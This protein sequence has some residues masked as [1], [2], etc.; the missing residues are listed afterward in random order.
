MTY[1]T[2]GKLNSAKNYPNRINTW[3]K[4]WK[5]NL[6]VFDYIVIFRF[7]LIFFVPLWILGGGTLVF[8]YYVEVQSKKISLEQSQKNLITLHKKII[9]EDFQ[10]LISNLSFLS[11][12]NELLQFLDGDISQKQKIALE[13]KTFSN[14]Q[15]YYDQIRFIDERGFEVVR[16]NNEDGNSAYIVPF[17]ELQYKGD[18]YYFR[19]T[20]QLT[21]GESFV[22][23]F[24]LNFENGKL[25]YPVKPVIRF[26]TSVFDRKNRK[27]GIV[28]FNYKGETLLHKLLRE[29]KNR[30]GSLIVLNKDSYWILA[31]DEED[32][33]GF[34]YN[35]QRRNNKF[36]LFNP[37]AWKRI[38]Q[39]LFGQFTDSTGMFTFITIFPDL[40]VK[41]SMAGIKN[42]EESMVFSSQ[43]SANYWK[44]ISHIPPDILLTETHPLLVFLLQLFGVLSA[45][46]FGISLLPTFVSI[47]RYQAEYSLKIINDELEKRV[48][49]RTYELR[50][51]NQKLREEIIERQIAETEVRKTMKKLADMKF[52]L[53]E[54]AIVG[55]TDPN[56]YLI[57]VN[58]QFCEITQS[59]RDELLGTRKSVINSE[60]LTKK[61]KLQILRTIS[62]GGVWKGVF[63]NRTK[64]GAFY[65]VD[66]TIVPLMDE[67]KKP[68]QYVVIHSDITYIK[69]AEA[70]LYQDMLENYSSGLAHEIGNPLG[71]IRMKVQTIQEELDEGELLWQELEDILSEIVRLSNIVK[72]FNALGRPS[73]PNFSSHDPRDL[74]LGLMPLIQSEVNQKRIRLKTEFGMQIGD[75]RVD[76]QQIQQVLLNLVVNAFQAMPN[77]GDLYLGV[78]KIREGDNFKV[79]FIVQDSGVGIQHNLLERIFDPFFTTKSKGSGFGLSLAVSA[80]KQNGGDIRVESRLGKG[81]EFY[82]TFPISRII[83]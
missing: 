47:R 19:Q 39:A 28:I 73:P 35:D 50:T 4:I 54:A 61:E 36:S 24:D 11:E 25:S 3:L 27:R 38:N 2:F 77:G 31:P 67:G 64:N 58:D 8:F 32:E 70:M 56:G 63:K 55:I 53:D 16:V 46:L 80:V 68:Y 62:S 82:L 13:Y 42:D 45:L 30:P 41:K 23:N 33:W 78:Q 34:M 49:E 1:F 9:S 12:Q 81:T 52:A 22:S 83:D 60:N 43:G 57:C 74:L 79:Q 15:R 21:K 48:H 66:T 10:L 26:G 7:F 17:S 18:R 40:E 29:S 51:T 37:G 59:T 71:A 20:F 69:Q 65:W 75:I 14:K 6:G 76:S 44:I 5:D 72:K